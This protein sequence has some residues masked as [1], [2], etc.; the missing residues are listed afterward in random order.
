M[1]SLRTVPT[2]RS[3]KAFACGAR[4]AVLMILIP[5]V[6]NT[7][8]KL[9]VNFVSLSPDEDLGR[10][11]TFGKIRGDVASLLHDPLPR[12][13]GGDAGEID[14]PGIELDEEQYVE[15]SEQHRIDG[16]EV[17]GRTFRGVVSVT[18]L[19]GHQE[20]S[21]SIPDRTRSTD[22]SPCR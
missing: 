18:T 13:V 6:R 15:A 4:T 17:T 12:W 9:D 3:A 2:N 22:D 1:H 7:S 16:E 10:S 19:R 14:P 5:S 20:C 11:G 21:G 8:S